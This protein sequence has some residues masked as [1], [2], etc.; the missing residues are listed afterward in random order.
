[1]NAKASVKCREEWG[2]T[3]RRRLS[4]IRTANELPLRDTRLNI[5]R[6]NSRSTIDPCAHYFLA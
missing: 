3:E 5:P 4:L 1:M 2:K 6:N